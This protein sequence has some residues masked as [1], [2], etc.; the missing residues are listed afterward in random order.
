[1]IPYKIVGKYGVYAIGA[2]KIQFTVLLEPTFLAVVKAKGCPSIPDG[3]Q[4][5]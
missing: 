4:Y 5:R 1:V 2:T 3:G